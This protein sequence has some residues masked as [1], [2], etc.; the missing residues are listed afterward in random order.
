MKLYPL[1]RSRTAHKTRCSVAGFGEAL[2]QKS[3]RSAY[4]AGKCVPHTVRGKVRH[5][6]RQPLCCAIG[7]TAS[8]PLRGPEPTPTT[9]RF[10]L[11]KPKQSAFFRRTR[12]EQRRKNNQSASAS[13][14]LSAMPKQVECPTLCGDIEE[15]AARRGCPALAGSG[16]IH[17]RCPHRRRTW[18]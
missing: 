18:G 15:V 8:K 1:L 11:Q 3:Q 12:L 4:G 16:S 5:T 13:R 7:R 17:S 6:L 2:R 14:H 9:R 10:T